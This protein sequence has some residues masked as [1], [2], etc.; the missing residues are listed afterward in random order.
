MRQILWMWWWNCHRKIVPR[1]FSFRWNDSAEE[2]MRSTIQRWLWRP[3]WTPWVELPFLLQG[4]NLKISSK[5]FNSINFSQIQNHQRETT[6]NAHVKTV[7]SLIQIH[8]FAMSSST[9]LTAMP[10]KLHAQLDYTLMNTL[11]LVCGLI[12]QTVKVA[13]HQKV[14]KIVQFRDSVHRDLCVCGC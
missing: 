6:R 10:S 5:L 14:R 8:K 4:I 12:Q 7:S 9:V 11:A 2:Q 1:R 3:Y 13:N